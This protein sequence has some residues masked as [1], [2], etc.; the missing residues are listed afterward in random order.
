MTGLS[1]T[2]LLYVWDFAAACADESFV[3]QAVSQIPGHNV[4]S[5]AGKVAVALS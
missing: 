3:Q 4:F 1:R 5:K 2:N